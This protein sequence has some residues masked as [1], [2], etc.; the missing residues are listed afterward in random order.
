MFSMKKL[1]LITA[2]LCTVSYFA[3]ADTQTGIAIKDCQG[4]SNISSNMSADY[5]LTGNID[6]SG[7]Y[8]Y[9]I[10]GT[11]TGTLD[12]QN[13]SIFRLEIKNKDGQKTQS[14]GLFREL[15]PNSLITRLNIYN[16]LI[17][18]H[19][20]AHRGVIAGEA[21]GGAEISH[22][23]VTYLQ[24]HR[25]GD[26]K[27][28]GVTGGMVGL[29]TG[30]IIISNVHIGRIDNGYALIA[31]NAYTGGLI[32]AAE[33]NVLIEKSSV[34]QLFNQNG[35][36]C[37]NGEG[38]CGFGGF[39]GLV[40]QFNPISKIEN[41][42]DI[43]VTINESYVAGG[44][45]SSKKNTGGMIG[46]IKANRSVHIK[47]SYTR[48]TMQ[49]KDDHCNYFGGL[50]GYTAAT[51]GHNDKDI[52]LENVYSAATIKNYYTDTRVRYEGGITGHEEG[53]LSTRIRNEGV[54]QSYFNHTQMHNIAGDNVSIGLDT[55][56]MKPAAPGENADQLFYLWDETIWRF[57]QGEYP[58]L[59]I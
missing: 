20:E 40:G 2:I 22:V 11:F 16:P 4:L 39:I 24:I 48:L 21:Y 28:H 15:G 36:T 1:S 42:S 17:K 44:T 18:A 25:T 49:C 41:N 10:E 43:N 27:D 50:F 52:I 53:Q 57:S 51:G 59:N 23:N 5:Y 32:G 56:Q 54:S 3:Q 13:W 46:L 34:T 12:G 19:D 8:H 26:G 14:T 38:E 31:Q 35:K 45:I 58:K 37:K 30:D 6:C 9:P 55:G 29:A 47:N 33:G 7:K